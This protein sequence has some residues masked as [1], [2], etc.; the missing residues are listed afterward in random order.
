MA[1]SAATYREI[2]RLAQSGQSTRAIAPQVGV[3]AETVRKI[4]RGHRPRCGTQ[5]IAHARRCDGCGG[6]VLEPICRLCTVR[7]L[8]A[9]RAVGVIS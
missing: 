7:R 4:R 6:L 5:G 3:S 2:Q 8:I 1:V 9:A